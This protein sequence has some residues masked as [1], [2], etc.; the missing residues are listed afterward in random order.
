[1]IKEIAKDIAEEILINA[2]RQRMPRGEKASSLTFSVEKLIR[3]SVSI[4]FARNRNNWAS[5]KKRPAA[6]TKSRYNASLSWR[7]HV[8]LAYEGMC[9][10]GYLTEEKPGVS[11]GPIGLYLTRYKATPKLMRRFKDLEQAI[12]PVIAHPKPVEQTIRV[13]AKE[14]VWNA[15]FKRMDTK[16]VLVEYQDND[17]IRRMR[18]N[19][20]RVNRVIAGKWIDLELS[21]D[22]FV[23][24]Q[25]RMRAR[26]DTNDKNDRQ[27]DLTRT[28]LYRVFNDTEFNTGGRFY[29][30]WWQNIPK[31]YRRLI[32]IDGKRT[33]EADY[34]NL[35]PAILYAQLGLHPP[36]DAYTNILPDLPRKVAKQAFNAMVNANQSTKVQ[37]RGMR[38]SDYGYRWADVVTAMFEKHQPIS[39]AFFRGAGRRLQRKDSELAERVMLSFLEYAEPVA[40]LPMHDSFIMHHGYETELKTLME[41]HFQ[42]MFGQAINIDMEYGD[43]GPIS[44]GPAPTDLD[45]LLEMETGADKRLSKFFA[46]RAT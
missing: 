36:S 44:I 23:A 34:S 46:L 35:H 8:K 29:G 20:D 38:L 6:Y 24:L 2:N 33:V 1:M 21:D 7:I 16:K 19:L 25:A 5:I 45:K 10:L 32:T 4:R 15:R 12:L 43:Y 39:E 28:Q 42:Q 30:G 14:P 31:R 13:Q 18:E 37:P 17:E 27:L 26:T 9:K 40:V 22:G 3:D 41:Q 11:N